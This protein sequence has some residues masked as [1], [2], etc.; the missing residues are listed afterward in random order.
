MNCNVLSAVVKGLAFIHH[1]LDHQDQTS[2]QRP[3]ILASFD[4]PRFF[5]VNDGTE[6]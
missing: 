1:S 4:F 2:T 3:A 5:E 6:F